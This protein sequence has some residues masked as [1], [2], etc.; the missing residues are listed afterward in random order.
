MRRAAVARHFNTDPLA[1]GEQRVALETY[2]DRHVDG[3]CAPV[4][5]ALREREATVEEVGDTVVLD[6]LA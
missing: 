5:R 6:A 4:L 1:E 2:L 3:P